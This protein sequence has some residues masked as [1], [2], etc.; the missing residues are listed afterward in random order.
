MVCPAALMA[1]QEQTFTKDF[2]EASLSDVFDYLSS[3][4][5]YVFTYNSTEV[6]QS[7]IRVT[8]S[9]KDVSLARILNDCLA[10]SPFTFEVVGRH[11]VIKKVAPQQPDM[12]KVSGKVV[13][14]KG[15]PLPGTTVVV[16]GTT[17]G[18]VTDADGHFTIYV[19]SLI[20][21]VLNFS[22]VG[23]KKEIVP[24]KGNTKLNVI[25]K[26]ESENLEEVTVVAFGEQKKESI[27]SS[28]TTVRPMDLKS[29]NSDLT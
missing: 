17:K 19:T 18:V 1:Q 22:F 2:K 28:I 24:I 21:D 20:D 12:I 14:E 10:N 13:D 8:R 7:A 9:F 25:L 11:V 26:P 5:D 15:N 29:S 6:R 4:S 16:H 3:H 27:V 23:Y